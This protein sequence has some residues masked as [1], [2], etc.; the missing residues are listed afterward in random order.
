[1]VAK[2]PTHLKLLAST[3][4]KDRDT[5]PEIDLPLVDSVPPPPLW[6]PNAHATNEWLRLA[7]ILIANKLLSIGALASFGQMCA[8]HGKI[9]QLYAAGESP[10]ASMIG[11][12]RNMHN[13]FGLTPASAGK[14]RGGDASSVPEGNSFSR[15]GKREQGK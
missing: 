8:L 14:V 3:D 5:F 10:G 15:V 13:D 4:R 12:L 11:A 6:L 9:V 1:M 7:P 2:V